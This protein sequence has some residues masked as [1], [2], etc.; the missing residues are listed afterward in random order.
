MS[1]LT[2][3]EKRYFERLFGMRSGYVL[4]FTDPTYEEFFRHYGIQIHD[5]KY[6]HYGSSKAKKLRAFWEIEE[7]D[8]VGRVLSEMVDY[9]EADEGMNGSDSNVALI[10]KC[11]QIAARLRT[12]GEFHS[13]QSAELLPNQ[14]PDTPT[15]SELP[16]KGVV[17]NSFTTN[18][19]GNQNVVATGANV[20]Q[21]IMPVRQ[22]DI[23]SLLSS[24][25]ELKLADEDLSELQTAVSS[26]PT[27]EKDSFGSKVSAWIGKM[28]SKAATGAF[29][30][31]ADQTTG[32]ILQALNGYYGN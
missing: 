7:D 21:E 4:D 2:A 16:F 25:R 27:A 18:I 28:A 10:E 15:L 26:E 30:F 14:Q 1:R 32:A 19:Y 3:P 17:Q 6:Q 12:Y 22:G 23:Q 24:L 5:S 11:R 20:H 8:M 31:G 29:K 9:Y 13:G